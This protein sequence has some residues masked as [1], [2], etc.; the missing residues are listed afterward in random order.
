MSGVFKGKTTGTPISIIIYNEDKRSRDYESIKNKFRPG[1][2]DFT[3]L[4]NME[5]EILGEVEDSQQEKPHG[6]AAGAVAKIVLKKF[7]KKI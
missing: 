2:A 3:Y 5:L 1:H 4:K 7:W 6:V